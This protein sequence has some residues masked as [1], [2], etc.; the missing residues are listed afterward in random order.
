MRAMLIQQGLAAALSTGKADE[1]LDEKAT[2]KKEELLAKSHLTMV[3]CLGGEGDYRGRDPNEIGESRLYSYKFQEEK[4]ILEQLEY[5]NKAIDDLENIDV[6]IKDEDKVI[7]LLNAL[8]KSHEELQDAIMYGREGTI[9]FFEVQS[10]LGAKEFPRSRS[11]VQDQAAES[12]N[13]KGLFDK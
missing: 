3:L 4:G 12:L 5:F 1:V 2:A 10:A 9:T 7:L 11:Q 13:I 8:S 6:T